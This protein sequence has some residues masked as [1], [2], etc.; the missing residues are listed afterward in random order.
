MRNKIIKAKQPQMINDDRKSTKLAEEYVALQNIL[1]DTK[2]K[3]VEVEP[4]LI[5][6]MKADNRSRITIGPRTIVVK[7]TESKEKIKVENPR[8]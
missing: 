2:E 1:E 8:V 3:M 7:Y 5:A 6:A 4:K